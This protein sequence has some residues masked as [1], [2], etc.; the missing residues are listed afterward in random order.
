MKENENNKA[1]SI[2][3]RLGQA[4]AITIVACTIVLI[5]GITIAILCRIF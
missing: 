1:K 5:I 3:Y 4:L 2:G